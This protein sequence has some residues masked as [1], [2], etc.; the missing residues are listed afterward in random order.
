MAECGATARYDLDNCLDFP[1]KTIPD[2]DALVR[3]KTVL[4]YGCGHGWQS[5][6]MSVHCNARRVFGIDI[7]QQRIEHGRQLAERYGCANVGFGDRVP[8][9]LT[10]AF[11]IVLSLS[12]FEHFAD[13]AGEVARMRSLARP[14]GLVV[15]SFAEPWYSN[16]GSHFNSYTR[17]PGTNLPLPWLNLVFSDRALLTLREQF[18]GDR[19]QRI[20]DIEGGLNKMTLARFE[21]IIRDSGLAV[22]ELRYYA[23]RGLPLVA[24]V[25]VVRELLTS[26]AMCMLR[27]PA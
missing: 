13:P 12:A 7:D 4:D 20:E 25:P 23:T 17:I 19:P 8:P 14:G 9:D 27:V 15:I 26:A 1:R 16:A 10:R 6:A 24:K 2:F 21:R 18:R 11:D 5:V 3:D 22:V